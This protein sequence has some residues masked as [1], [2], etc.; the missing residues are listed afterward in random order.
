MIRFFFCLFYTQINPQQLFDMKIL[1][2]LIY[3]GALFSLIA[4]TP[5][6]SLRNNRAAAPVQVS[7]GGRI[8]TD[9]ELLG[10]DNG[11]KVWTVVFQNRVYIRTANNPA[12]AHNNSQVLYNVYKNG[13]RVFPPDIYTNLIN[14]C[15]NEEDPSTISNGYL[16]P[17]VGNV[18][19][20]N[21]KPI[22]DRLFL[23]DYIGGDGVRSKQY[24]RISNGRLR[25]N[26]QRE[27]SAVN[28]DAFSMALIHQTIDHENGSILDP[29]LGFTLSH[30]EIN[31]CFWKNDPLL[32][33]VVTAAPVCAGGPS[34]QSISNI[35]KTGLRFG[36]VGTS[37][38][39]VKW[40]ITQNNNVQRSGT[41][42]Q[43]SGATTVELNF[44]SLN[45]GNYELE[46]E[47]GDCTS[48][49]SSLAFT[50]TE[51]V[52]VIPAC[53][54]G[55]TITNITAITSNNLTIDFAGTGIPN[56][57]W[58]IKR[59]N[60][61]LAS[62]KTA[63]LASNSTR[64]SY[65]NLVNGTY[66]LEIQ[67]GDC[68]SGV[69]SQ[70]FV[71][72]ANCLSGP[73]LQAVGDPTPQGLNFLFDG[74]GVYGIKWKIMQGN[75]VV[76]ES[77][78]S[79]QNNRPAISYQPLANGAYTLAIEGQTCNSAE[80][81]MAFRI[82]AA[83]PLPI[84][85]AS[86]EAKAVEKGVDLS[87][88]VVSE[89]NG[90]GFQILRLNNELKTSDVIGKISLTEQKMGVYHFI[91]ENPAPGTNYYQLKQIDLDGTFTLSKVIG[92][93]F[94]EIFEAFVSPNPANDHVNVQFTS[95]TSGATAVEVYDMSG[96]RLSSSKIDMKEGKN[97]YRLNIGN[98]SSGQ[99]FI[100]VLNSDEGSALKFLKMN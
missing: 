99:Y 90:E 36:F 14:G 23:G 24:A 12:L 41:T 53:N 16:Q 55:P 89:K 54:G 49:V 18:I 7:C 43:L 50:I 39:N 44:N 88:K 84:Y 98:F 77:N 78:V 13:V 71:V 93:R 17:Q 4:A 96:V 72:S 21:N 91:D 29:G 85:I 87:W 45:A 26:L 97:N 51:P 64:I 74:N 80:S 3:V 25:V 31:S 100:K 57:T 60:T 48:S 86:F 5:Y 59:D 83:D 82:G 79:P 94:E 52:V 9:G 65:D 27:G 69:S 22:T 67:G 95:R 32:A 10:E 56:I 34:I 47:G 15:V 73:V 8:W 70:S 28:F 35:S 37:I 63:N 38:P 1:R 20:C 81:T 58:R 92:V 76:R 68:T 75:N 2:K 11:E 61:V 46:I 19:R 66:T 6:D 42:G 40:R 62:A 33:T 30:L